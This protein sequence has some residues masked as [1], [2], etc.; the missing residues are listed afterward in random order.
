MESGLEESRVLILT[1]SFLLIFQPEHKQTEPGDYCILSASIG[2]N[3]IKSIQKQ[4]SEMGHLT[5]NWIQS[6]EVLTIINI[7]KSNES[8]IGRC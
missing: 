7:G 2:I 1:D 8:K 6:Q 3:H 4:I 5:I